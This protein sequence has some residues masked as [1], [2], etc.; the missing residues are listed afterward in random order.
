M[1]FPWLINRGYWPL[2]NWD[3]PPS[4]GQLKIKNP[5]RSR[6]PVIPPDREFGCLIGMFL[7]APRHTEAQFRSVAG[8]CFR[9]NTNNN[10]WKIAHD[11][12]PI[13]QILA[14]PYLTN[15][16]IT[17]SHKSWHIFTIGLT[18]QRMYQVV[19][20]LFNMGN[21]IYPHWIIGPTN[22]IFM[23][24]HLWMSPGCGV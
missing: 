18:K 20:S 7:G 12:H 15:P 14:S 6:Y 16:G 11:S 4:S 19:D 8:S 22:G 2:T 24:F 3:D 1:A 13:S 21:L 10:F 9:L 17:I 5:P 23:N